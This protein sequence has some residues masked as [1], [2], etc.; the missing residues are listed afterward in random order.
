MKTL[1]HVFSV[2]EVPTAPST[3]PDTKTARLAK[4]PRR[5]FH[6][7][8]LSTKRHAAASLAAPLHAVLAVVVE[9]EVILGDFSFGTLWPLWLSMALQRDPLVS[10]TPLSYSIGCWNHGNRGVA[11]GCVR[12]LVG[13]R[14]QRV[15]YLWRPD[16]L[17]CFMSA[18]AAGRSGG[19]TLL[20]PTRTALYV[21]DDQLRRQNRVLHHCRT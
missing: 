6:R 5:V 18:C 14:P 1:S 17:L 11:C 13:L 12:V 20:R 8:T 10:A 21:Q 4:C 2:S 7:D 16:H 19:G 3:W 15:V 9:K